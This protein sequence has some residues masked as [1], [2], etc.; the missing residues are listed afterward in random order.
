MAPAV[1]TGFS[2]QT[3]F[4]GAVELEEEGVHFFADVGDDL[5]LFGGAGED[6]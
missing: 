4:T 2:F 3:R 5:A 6:V 1:F